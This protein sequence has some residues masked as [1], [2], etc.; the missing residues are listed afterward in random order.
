MALFSLK[1]IDLGFGGPL[2]LE[3]VNLQIEQ[4]ERIGLLGRNGEGKSTLLKLIHGSL[5]PDSGQIARLAGLKSAYLPQ[6]VPQNLADSVYTVVKNGLI[7][8]RG[9]SIE[10]WQQELRVDQ[11]IARMQ[12]DAQADYDQL[13]AGMKRRVLLARSLVNEPQTLLLDE[14]TNHLDI[15]AIRW[16]EEFLLRWQGTLLFV[17]H[18]RMFLQNVST[19]II[20]LDR[21]RLF[22]WNC[23]YR[24]FQERKQALLMAED[25]QAALFDRKL[26]QEEHWIRQGIEARRTRNEGRVR[27]LLRLR[28]LRAERREQPRK[29]QLQVQAER[30]TGMLVIEVK[31]IHF[32]WGEQ[33]IV[34]DLSTIICRGDKIGIIG[35]NGS[36]KTTL[37]RLLLGQIQPKKGQVTLGTNLD[38][39]YFDQL[40]SQLDEGK[41]VLENVAEGCDVININGHNRNIYSYLEDFL[42]SKE[43]VNA[44]IHML[45][46]G[47][48]NRLLLAKIFAQ[49]ANLIVMDEPTND[50]DI[51]SMEVLEDLLLDFKGTLILVSHDREFLNNLVTST[52]VLAGEGE[53]TEFVGGYD[54][55]QQQTNKIEEEKAEAEKSKLE[56]ESSEKTLSQGNA[57]LRKP[58]YR[59]KRE[60]ESLQKELKELPAR[61][62]SL[63]A[64]QHKLSLEMSD[65]SFYQQSGESISAAR[66]LLLDIEKQ[67]ENAYLRWEELESQFGEK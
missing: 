7:A 15:F 14:P 58:T 66:S 40:R 59:E 43:R 56:R 57:G 52:I 25:A 13:S 63:E 39:A 49:P 12:L 34:N 4:G 44:P 47:E 35:S 2:I 22:D 37:L 11:V 51:D 64:A 54:D 27:A 65:S 6:D 33:V 28:S 26:A 18:D 10:D 31:H 3:Q 61:I 19:R 46:G 9:E 36:G 8:A 53:V 60:L 17:T 16:L 48:R 55:W 30:R 67:L 41:S 32:C 23:D 29:I 1:D 45:S 50:L 42:F 5:Q 20:E 38:I 62:E 24:T 21:G